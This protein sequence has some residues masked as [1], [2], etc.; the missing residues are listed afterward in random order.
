MDYLVQMDYQ[1]LFN[2]SGL[3]HMGELT[4]ECLTDIQHI[5]NSVAYTVYKKNDSFTTKV[6]PACK[7]KMSY[8]NCKTMSLSD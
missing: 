1:A 2:A 6:M 5:Q 8:N 3:I 4:P 7:L